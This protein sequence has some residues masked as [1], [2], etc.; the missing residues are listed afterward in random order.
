[1]FLAVLRPGLCSILHDV[2]KEGCWQSYQDGERMQKSNHKR[3]NSRNSAI[4]AG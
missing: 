4:Q 1:M 3:D 2:P